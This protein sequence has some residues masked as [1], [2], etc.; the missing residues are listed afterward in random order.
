MK[1]KKAKKLYQRL[2]SL[3]NRCKM[4][5][6]FI[7]EKFYIAPTREAI[8]KNKIQLDWNDVFDGNSFFH[9]GLM[10]NEEC[11]IIALH[12]ASAS[13]ILK[14][15]DSKGFNHLLLNTTE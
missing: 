3:E 6:D 14:E 7:I 8:A 12:R 11:E 4:R 2:A 15:Y 10:D 5:T 13:V 9:S 1:V